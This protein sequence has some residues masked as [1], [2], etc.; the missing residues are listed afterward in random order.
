MRT[1][2]RKRAGLLGA[3]LLALF[4]H[5]GA[6]KS[7]PLLAWIPIDLT[8][9]LG[10]VLILCILGEI[11][12]TKRISKVIFLPIAIAA[13]MAAGIPGAASEY[14]FD[15]IES[16]F[17]LTALALV[18]AVVLLRSQQQRV[19]FLRTLAVLGIIVAVLVTVAPGQ[20]SE[21]STVPTL[22][23]TNTISTAQ[24]I[25]NGAIVLLMDVFVGHRRARTRILMLAL[26]AVMLFTALSTGSR[27]PVVA[28]AIGV[29]VALLFAPAFSR[30]R[31]R[32][33][34][35][36]AALGG[37]AL[38]VLMQSQGEGLARVATFLAGE[39]DTSVAARTRFWD[40]AHAHIQVLPLG[41]GW[42]YFGIQPEVAPLASEG[43]QLYPHSI[44]LEIT[45]EAGWFAGFS[46][47]LFAIVTLFHLLR[48]SVD[49]VSLTFLVFLVYTLTNAML[50]G[51]I[52]DNRLMW[53]VLVA[54]W[55]IPKRE[56][57]D[58]PQDLTDTKE[59]PLARA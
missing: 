33:I 8:V 24:I 48:R 27:G 45:L 52:N 26:A 2:E 36:A 16:F 12:R 5:A 39:Q 20:V 49:R 29:I 31:F 11:F 13:V 54:A 46:L 15:K 9:L 43:G 42:G 51:D 55:M 59:R 14:G 19:V 30:R 47:T 40:V 17:T 21:W 50:S 35:A 57:A 6:I 41:G 7:H 18:G 34:L 53:V 4:V 25:M 3:V 38:V 56:A 22:P 28:V 58:S 44:M 32:T 10:G 37:T 1:T 23:G